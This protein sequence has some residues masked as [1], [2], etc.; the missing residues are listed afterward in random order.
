[1]KSGDEYSG[2][3]RE[4]ISIALPMVVSNA[5][6]TVM[7][8]TDR[9]YLSRL[10]M[11][12]M[13]AA[14]AGGISAFFMMTFF[15][16]LMG[17]GTAMVAQFLG[18]GT[19]NKCSA[20]MTQMLIISF[21]AYPLLLACKPLMHMLFVE[22]GMS[23]IQLQHQ[24]VYFDM[25]LYASII[26]FV[27]V[28]FSSFFSGIGKTR[29]VMVASFTA[30]LV[31]IIASYILIFGKLGLAPM[32]IKGAAYGS[33]LGSIF[34]LLILLAAYLRREIVRDYFVTDS[35]RFD[36][37]IIKRM[38]RFGTPSGV[39]FFMALFS[40]TLMVSLF[41]A[42]SPVTATGATI[43]FN[44]DHVSF[45]PLVGLEI[46]VT[47]LAG[48]YVGAKRYDLVLKTVWSGL[49]IGWVVSACVLVLFLFFPG[50]LADVFKP[51]ETGTVF[52]QARPLAVFMIRMASIY[53]LLQVVM[54]VYMG[55]LKGAG[56]TLWSMLANV[57]FMWLIYLV[58]YI[59]LNVMDLSAEAAWTSLVFIFSFLPM[60]LYL[61]FR[62]GKWK[63]F[64]VV[65]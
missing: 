50:G 27:R 33:I 9:L 38:F 51:A 13:N 20:V 29:V 55:A 41:H 30:M 18:K 62:S 10:G 2:S 56:D 54:L 1:L 35:F 25:L 48:R 40:F 63:T 32:G 14:M 28:A 4:M 52:E 49:K 61:R 42:H 22:S 59:F 7:I 23:S 65:G 44:W 24:L 12:E 47:S 21:A 39:E 46:G 34:S 15:L 19:L 17:Y 6:E 26:G 60:I 11:E 36:L 64:D 31:N 43:M 37:D 3:I 58:L 53:V 8:F 5:C 57:A 16:G 45:V